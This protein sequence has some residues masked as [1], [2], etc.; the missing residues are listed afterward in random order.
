MSTCWY[1]MCFVLNDRPYAIFLVF[2]NTLVMLLWSL[3]AHIPPSALPSCPRP[4][5]PSA[6]WQTCVY[7]FG[8]FGECVCIC[9]FA[10]SSVLTFT[11]ETQV[12][13]PVTRMM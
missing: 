2:C 12:S 1:S 7:F 9:C 11:N 5:L 4:Q 8:L 6:F 13:S 3:V 10:C